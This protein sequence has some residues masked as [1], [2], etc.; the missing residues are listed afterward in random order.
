MLEVDFRRLIV[1]EGPRSI[2]GLR[3]WPQNSGV[4]L[5]NAGKGKRAF[6]A[7]PPKGAADISGILS[8]E[9]YRVEI[10]LKSPKARLTREQDLFGKAIIALGGIYV[11]FRMHTTDGAKELPRCIDAIREAIQ[12]RRDRNIEPSKQDQ[13]GPQK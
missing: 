2:S 10:E 9:G 4:V 5:I 8:P 7:G 3:V 6:H 13:A 12:R 1:L 11:L